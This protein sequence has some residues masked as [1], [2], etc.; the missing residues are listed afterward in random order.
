MTTAA[1]YP[2][3]QFCTRGCGTKEQTPAMSLLVGW[4]QPI[5]HTIKTRKNNNSSISNEERERHYLSFWYQ[6]G[7]WKPCVSRCLIG[8]LNT[9]LLLAI[10]RL[11]LPEEAVIDWIERRTTYGELGL[12]ASLVVQD[13]NTSIS[14][15]MIDCALAFWIEAALA[16]D[17]DETEF[18]W[19]PLM[20]AHMYIGM[21][22]GPISHIE[23]AERGRDAQHSGSLKLR[24]LV[25]AELKKF[26]DK[27]FEHS[28]DTL[29]AI[30]T[31][32]PILAFQ[33]GKDKVDDILKVVRNIRRRDVE[34]M[35]EFSRVTLREV[36]RGRPP[37]TA[38]T[39]NKTNRKTD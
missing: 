1:I 38:G 28:K 6:S 35:V 3:C 19:Q 23:F 16:H 9:I 13:S 21:A 7:R 39:H 8:A 37:K 5:Q 34:V 29:E 10:D 31:T 18:A 33:E 30:T 32:K 22:S 4:E 12:P 14:E 11:K 26:A 17:R 25:L 15:H 27:Q 2:A 24:N 36:R 20:Q